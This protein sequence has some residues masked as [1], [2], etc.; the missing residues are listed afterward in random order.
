L[1]ILVIGSG[2]REHAL[3]WKIAQSKRVSKIFCAPGNPGMA[4]DGECVAIPVSD[5]P[6]LAE[7]AQREQIGLTVVGPEDPLAAGVV[8][9][10]QE[11]GLRIFGPTSA[12]AQLE[13]SKVFSKQFLLKHGI[14]TAHAEVFDEQ[15]AALA[16][17]DQHTP[18]MVIKADGLA[19]GKGVTV[20]HHREDARD[21]VRAAMEQQ[22]F[23]EAGRR[24]IIEEFLQGQEA[25][26][27]ALCDG[28]HV[29]PLESAADHKPVNDDDQGPNTG[30]MGCYSPV[31]AL[32][33]ELYH[34]AKRR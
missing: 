19:Q 27:M 22:I 16:Y 13:A 1:R 12:A 9:H 33:N 2:G 14:P 21:A 23:G 20:A 32:T 18:P 24:V 29:L 4:Q 31:P 30:G 17:L 28:E 7:F 10:F 34:E 25:T 11:R 5:L 6:A 15:K 3:T 8:D 26:V